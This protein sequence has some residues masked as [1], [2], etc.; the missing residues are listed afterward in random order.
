MKSAINL[1]SVSRPD[2]EALPLHVGRRRARTR[3]EMGCKGEG[4]VG[5]G[6]KD[7]RDKTCEG[8]TGSCES[9]AYRRRAAERYEHGCGIMIFGS[10]Q[11]SR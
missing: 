4:G 5:G 10:S 7:K 3:D 9:D 8:V 11:D 1:R 6:V 2:I